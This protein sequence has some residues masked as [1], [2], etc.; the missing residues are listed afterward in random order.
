MVAPA[1]MFNY[2]LE[3]VRPSAKINPKKSYCHTA[4]IM[5]GN[6]ILATA[7]N[8]SG[9]RSMGSGYSQCTIH[10]E[11]DCLKKLGDVS[12]LKGAIMFVW[13]FDKTCTRTMNSK[14]CPSC[15]CVLNKCVKE[16]GLKTV[17]Y[18]T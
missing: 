6:K 12:K 18:T 16:Y 8:R 14:P 7:T 3:T 1:T 11:M 9:T 5:K 15:Q 13:R 17:F 2:L 10:A 4:V